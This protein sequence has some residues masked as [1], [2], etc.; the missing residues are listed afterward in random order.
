MGH[1]LLLVALLSASAVACA[2][3][4]L[5]HWGAYDAALYRHYQTPAERQVWVEALKT[6]VLEAEQDGG[7]VPPGLYAEY[8]FVLLEE[9]NTK[10][11]VA[12]FEKEKA[13]WPESTVL[14]EKMIRNAGQRP[15]KP[16]EATG[17]ATQVEAAVPATPAEA[18]K[19]AA[20][21]E[22]PR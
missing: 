11:A 18:A 9:G 19:P 4:P 17:P 2:P 14:M 16:A 10:D 5:Y 6:T 3:R 21:V 20:P 22:V 12:Y 8:G 7:R 15:V 1:R 13:K